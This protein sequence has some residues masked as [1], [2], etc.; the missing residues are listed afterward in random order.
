MPNKCSAPKCRSNYAGEQPTPVFKIPDGPPEIVALWKAFLHREHI[1][2]IKKIYVCLKH[3]QDEDV[4]THFSIPQ[5]DGTR[6]EVKR[7]VPRLHKD[8][9]PR[10]LPGCPSYLSNLTQ[11]QNRLDRCTKE[12]DQLDA[13]IKQ[14]LEQQKVEEG[15]FKLA[16]LCE[17]K[18][19]VHSLTLPQDWLIWLRGVNQLHFLKPSTSHENGAHF[20]ECSLTIDESLST[21]GFYN[22]KRLKRLSN[23]IPDNV[24]NNTLKLVSDAT[25]VLNLAIDGISKSELEAHNENNKLPAI[26][27]IHCQLKNLLCKK[28]HRSYNIGTIIIALKCQLISPACYQYLQSLDSLSLPH[29]ST[30]KRLY[31]KFGLDCEYSS[32]LERATSHFSQRERNVILQMDEIH[33]KSELT[34][35]GG[36]VFGSS[37]NT[38]EPAK[39]IFAFMV[40]SLSKKWS[41][42]VRLLPCS[43][44][45]ASELFP[46][47]KMV[48]E[49]IE[50]CGLYVQVLC[51]DNYP[52]NVSIFKLFSPN[53]TLNTIVPHI[54][55]PNRPLFLIFDFVHIIKSIRNN[56]INQKDSCR[57]FTYPNFED[58]STNYTASFENIRTLYKA[59]Q[60]SIAKLAPRLTAKAC[61]PSNLERQNVNLA[62]KVFDDSTHS[63]LR[64]QYLSLPHLHTY[65]H[66]A[67]F[68][69]VV[70]DIWKMFNINTPSK[71][72]RLNDQ[73]CKPFVENDPRFCYL[74]QVVDWL[75]KWEKLPGKAGKLT[76]QT[77][78]SFRHSTLALPSIVNHL[79]QNCNFSFVLTSFLQ[80]DPLE[81]HFGI[82]RMMSG[83]QYHISFCQ[84]LES[85]RRLK[86]SNILKIFSSGGWE[87]DCSIKEFINSFTALTESKAAS[88]FQIEHFLPAVQNL[89]L[90]NV[91]TQTLQ[92]LAFIAGYTVYSYFKNSNRCQSCL[93]FLTEDKEMEIETSE[94]IYKLLQI[95]D[96]GALKWPSG[97]VVNV[98]VCLWRIF[99]SLEQQPQ[100]FQDLIR[101]PSRQLIVNLTLRVIED[102]D[103]VCW[104]NCCLNC[105]IIGWDILNK[106]L[107]AA[108]NCFLS[109]KIKNLN[110]VNKRQVEHSRK[111]K[112]FKSM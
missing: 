66:T 79:T 28:N 96:R 23:E 65:H 98:I 22:S 25:E 62:L 107:T 105:Q 54:V 3:F 110:A 74:S 106:L 90:V 81:H 93:S 55:D 64:L 26:Q 45:S 94:S 85:E 100:L 11:K 83:A 84:I 86:L 69:R 71:S 39:T 19:K 16:T 17:L 60:H 6:L 76:S 103:S 68:I 51:T 4:E 7:S 32:F 108:A 18:S 104:R 49:D 31:S 78:K 27:F 101:G 15:K 50:R 95:M 14:S 82:Y 56:W 111:L 70:C 36:K 59:D 20:I 47:I 46:I 30:L 12:R 42:I 87:Q 41:T 37:L 48:I 43:N 77:F 58:F 21:K 99:T 67:V 1:E 80:N 8:A 38:I 92:A 73:L 63:A 2:D 29:Y 9:I 24:S 97:F 40:S 102:E 109:N 35:K 53:N 34:Y 13:A 5:P 88:H 44:S 52:M 72:I 33:V 57:S 89:S 112:K 91:P 10:I 75:E 61:W